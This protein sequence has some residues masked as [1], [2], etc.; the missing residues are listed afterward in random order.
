MTPDTRLV[1]VEARRFRHKERGSTYTLIGNGKAQC[2]PSGLLDDENVVIYQGDDGSLWARRH[3]EFWDGR[4][5]EIEAAPALPAAE[6][7]EECRDAAR[8][9]P[10]SA[11]AKKVIRITNA[12]LSQGEASS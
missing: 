5:E 1:P 11:T 3:A 9:H 2:S 4:F 8:A 6:A 12:A 10:N 7:L